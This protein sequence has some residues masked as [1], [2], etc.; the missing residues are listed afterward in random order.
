VVGFLFDYIFRD[1]PSPPVSK[2]LRQN[3]LPVLKAALLDQSI[4]TDKQNPARRLLEELAVAATGAEDDEAYGAAF[5]EVAPRLR[6]RFATI[7]FWTRTS[8]L[9]A[10]S[11]SRIH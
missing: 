4:F 10:A 6:P 8:L 3:Q 7:S 1:L 9:M 11:G 2:D 5:D